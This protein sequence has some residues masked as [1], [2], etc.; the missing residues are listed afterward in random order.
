MDP[1]GDEVLDAELARGLDAAAPALREWCLQ[2]E[3]TYELD[4]WFTNGRSTALVGV[5]YETDHHTNTAQKLVLKLDTTTAGAPGAAEYTRQRR[6]VSESPKFAK[7]HLAE[8]AE[9]GHDLV[10]VGDGRWILFQKIA[11][12]S[13]DDLDVMTKLLASVRTGGPV[14]STAS[15]HRTITCGSTTFARLCGRIVRGVLADWQ[16]KPGL[17]RTSVT[18]LLDLHLGAR[19]KPG[20]PLDNLAQKLTATTLRIPGEPD[21]LPNPFALALDTRLTQDIPVRA[22]VGKAH[23]DL[24]TEN[25]LVPVR[26]SVDA[27]PFRLIDLAKYDSSAP[28]TRDPVHLLLYIIARAMPDLSDGQSDALIDELIAPDS[29]RGAVLPEWLRTL[30]TTVRRT[31]EEWTFPSG[32]VA[33]WRGQT[34]L[35]LLACALMFLARPST[36]DT[37]RLWFLRLAARAGRAYLG[38]HRTPTGD[39]AMPVEEPILR[40][41]LSR[42]TTAGEGGIWVARLCEYLPYMKLKARQQDRIAEVEALETGAKTGADLKEPFIELVRKL[43]GPT[44]GLRD[45]GPDSHPVDEVYTCP[46]S[47]PCPRAERRKPSDPEPTCHLK[48]GTMRSEFW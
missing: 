36:R 25:I 35:S 45:P 30:I 24:H 7:R 29:G 32:L 1:H 40:Q 43:G 21:P 10:R 11:S 33:E 4:R 48:P 19:L 27:S 42:T 47:V 22:L 41:N 14:G 13:L 28:L 12:G 3:I 17:Q 23:G 6:A 46:L 44:D 31:G 15:A 39:D 16:G 2:K 9:P 34:Q 8:L 38:P 18:G 37:D 20:G 5:V 26:D